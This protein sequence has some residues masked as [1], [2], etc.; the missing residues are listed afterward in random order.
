MD[1]PDPELLKQFE[2][3]LA[4]MGPADMQELLNRL[5]G[6]VDASGGTVPSRRRE[7][8]ADV[9][10]YRVRVDLTGT[11]PPLWRRLEL[12]SDTHL[13]ELHDVI[14]IA[15]GWTDSH[16]HRF[17]MGASYDRDTEHFLCPF[18]VDEGEEGTPEN[19]VRVDEVLADVDDK[20]LYVYDFGDDWQHTLRLEAVLP[21]NDAAPRATCTDGRRPGP[22]EDCGGPHGYELFSAASDPTHADHSAARAEIARI[23][24]SDV[25]PEGF[26]PTPFDV[27]EINKELASLPTQSTAQLPEPLADLVRAVRDT[28]E[29]IRL[30]KLISDAGL[31][32]PT[33]IDADT[34]ARMVRPYAWLLDRV[35]DDGITLTGAGYLPPVHV[36]A[37]VAELGMADEW[38]GKHNRE[39]Q[40]MPVL[41]L[42]ESAQKMGLLRKHRGKLLAT[43]RGLKLRTDPVGLWWHVAERMPL[44]SRDRCESHAGLIL[45]IGIAAGA[46]E[47]DAIIVRTLHAIGWMRGDGRPLT[48]S[49]AGHAAWDTKAVLRRLGALTGG[50]FR[51]DERPTPDGIA[52]ARAAL[53]AWP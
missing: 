52:F 53:R 25:E 49:D 37:A 13:D 48:G 23:Y 15:F 40:T 16:L 50:S 11:K 12:A 51:R 26:A 38:I 46:S 8:R 5:V 20:L 18:D 45:L 7:R 41:N 4:D 1:K 47:D 14:Q 35:G 44:A 27:S 33:V 42:R 22:P 17:S 39:S 29:Q 9:V 21:R 28:R 2:A 19:Q 24:G 34:A 32:Q 6:G 36:E 31:D 43:T 30:R 10:T 3:E